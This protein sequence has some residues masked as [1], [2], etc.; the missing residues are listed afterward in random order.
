MSPFLQEPESFL[1]CD[2]LRIALNSHRPSW[3]VDRNAARWNKLLRILG[4]LTRRNPNRAIKLSPSYQSIVLLNLQQAD[5]RQLPEAV[6][7][8]VYLKEV[9]LRGN[10]LEEIPQKCAAW[11]RLEICDFSDNRL[12]SV[13]PEVLRSWA[14][15]L[16]VL[17]LGRNE[18]R[19][20]PKEIGE[21][22]ELVALGL[23]GNLLTSL[24]DLSGLTKLNALNVAHN[25]LKGLP[26]SVAKCVALEA[27]F[28]FNNEMTRIPASIGRMPKLHSLF[29]TGNHIEYL[30]AEILEIPNLVLQVSEDSL[31]FQLE[32]ENDPDYFPSL[33]EIT[34]RLILSLQPPLSI[35][36]KFPTR[37]YKLL[38]H[39][40]LIHCT[41]CHRPVF[42]SPLQI[43]EKSKQ[44][45][46]AIPLLHRVCSTHC[47]R[48]IQRR[49]ADL[50]Q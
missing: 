22:T 23:R 7:D 42:E 38:R 28:A 29:L 17:G 16:K 31:V 46:M 5:L 50:L 25:K 32:E 40:Q 13:P 19:E 20:L 18:I 48:S 11:T 1:F 6:F 34:G 36:E 39:N 43:L 14:S 21:L 45:G 2:G 8:L 49:N 9:R 4:S 33:R 26:L 24:P 30:P 44:F 41:V 27:I 15:T 12:T 10:L 47:L 37:L 35:P 3:W